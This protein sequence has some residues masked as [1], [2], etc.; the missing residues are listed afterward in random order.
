VTVTVTAASLFHDTQSCFR[1]PEP[2]A[3]RAQNPGTTAATPLAGN[4]I[5][6]KSVESQGKPR[7]VKRS[8]SFFSKVLWGMGYVA[9]VSLVVIAAGAM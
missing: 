4:S 5:N 1:L 2:Y 6:S 3:D 7:F 8:T 9:M